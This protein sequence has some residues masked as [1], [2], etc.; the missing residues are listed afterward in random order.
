M[1]GRTPDRVRYDAFRREL[2]SL[3]QRLLRL[4][5]EPLIPAQIHDD[6]IDMD[7][8]REAF[9]AVAGERWGE[10]EAVLTEIQ[11]LKADIEALGPLPEPPGLSASYGAVKMERSG[12]TPAA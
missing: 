1:W 5:T 3:S 10:I 7:V 2:L 9:Y 12:A 4:Q 8:A 6:D 11:T